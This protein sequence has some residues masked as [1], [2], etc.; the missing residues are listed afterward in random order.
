MR[1]PDGPP[2]PPTGLED[3]RA[4]YPAVRS[5]IRR[6]LPGGDSAGLAQAR[7]GQR[8]TAAVGPEGAATAD[9]PADGPG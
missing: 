8:R 4:L 5:H 7:R 1:I 3:L 6:H 9:E 2:R